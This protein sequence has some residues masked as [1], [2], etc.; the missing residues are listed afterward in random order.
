MSDSGLILETNIWTRQDDCVE[1]KK[2]ATPMR[3]TGDLIYDKLLWLIGCSGR[4]IGK[5]LCIGHRRNKLD[6]CHLW[7]NIANIY[8]WLG[9]MKMSE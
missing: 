4:E 8:W 9:L 2:S 7:A 3:I 6:L 5:D 1:G